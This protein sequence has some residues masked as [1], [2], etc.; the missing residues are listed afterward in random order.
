LSKFRKIL[1]KKPNYN[2]QT[3]KDRL[4]IIRKTKWKN[5]TAKRVWLKI[6]KLVEPFFEE[7]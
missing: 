6:K 4:E 2:V 3:E 7:H 1:G 5:I